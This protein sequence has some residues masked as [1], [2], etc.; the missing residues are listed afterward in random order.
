ME[1]RVKELEVRLAA[2]EREH[3][4]I[5]RQRGWQWLVVSCLV[6]SIFSMAAMSSEPESDSR[7]RRNI[8]TRSLHIVNDKGDLVGSF[9][10][11]GEKEALLDLG[12]GRFAV[13]TG[14]KGGVS[15]VLDHKAPGYGMRI[16]AN[17]NRDLRIYMTNGPER[18]AL[19]LGLRADGTSN[20]KLSSEKVG[21]VLGQLD[22]ESTGLSVNQGDSIAQVFTTSG[23]GKAIK[24]RAVFSTEDEYIIAEANNDESDRMLEIAHK[25]EKRE[26][27]VSEQVQK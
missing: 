8:T 16:A 10:A 14:D 20:L 25:K 11:L 1:E 15:L 23:D 12:N 21:V 13:Q 3:A 2:M 24:S 18:A 4:R 5:K 27:R 9:G 26:F 6:V 7:I 22:S 19:S 17:E